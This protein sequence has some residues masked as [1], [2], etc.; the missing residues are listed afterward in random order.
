MLATFDE[1][2]MQSAVGNDF[3]RLQPARLDS[4]AEL[5]QDINH[6]AI[7]FAIVS[8]IRALCGAAEPDYRTLRPNRH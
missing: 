1:A 4:T 5:T 3:L 6:V 7:S 8:P 2:S